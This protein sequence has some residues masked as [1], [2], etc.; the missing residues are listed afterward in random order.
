M[1]SK[2]LYSGSG[3]YGKPTFIGKQKLLVLVLQDIRVEHKELSSF[4]TASP[5]Y[6][7]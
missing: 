3:V 1:L 7:F 6:L 5:G 2:I 4:V